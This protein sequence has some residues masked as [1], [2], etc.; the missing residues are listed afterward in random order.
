M[1]GAQAQTKSRFEEKSRTGGRGRRLDQSCV[2][3][4]GQIQRKGRSARIHVELQVPVARGS[5]DAQLDCISQCSIA[6]LEHLHLQAATLISTT[7]LLNCVRVTIV[8][9]KNV[10]WCEGLRN[11]FHEELDDTLAERLVYIGSSRSVVK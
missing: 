1:P 3:R 6:S 11:G 5:D 8:I 10:T 7:S 9:C 4:C 2:Y